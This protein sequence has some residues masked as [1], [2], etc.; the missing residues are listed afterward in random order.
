MGS[1]AT[2]PLP[3]LTPQDK[4][5]VGMTKLRHDEGVPFDV[6]VLKATLQ[7]EVVPKEKHVRTLKIGCSGSAPRQQVNYIIHSL[8]KRL[9]EKSGW[10]VT[11][12][13]LIVFH[14]LMREVDP[15]FQVC[16]CVCVCVHV[17]V[18]VVQ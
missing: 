1:C 15:S 9:E 12:K 7:D 2:A 13:T 4:M 3:A 8:G 18:G 11:L 17:Y 5:D 16:V 6:A 10:L 14:R